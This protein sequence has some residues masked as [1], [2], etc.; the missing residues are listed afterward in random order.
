[1]MNLPS[2]WVELADLFCHVFVLIVCVHNGVDLKSNL[3]KIPLVGPATTHEE[4]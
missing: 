3:Q 2:H 4:A 1:M